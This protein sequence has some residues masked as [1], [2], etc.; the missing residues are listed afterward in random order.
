MY[1]APSAD[2]YDPASGFPTLIKPTK[3]EDRKLQ[4]IVQAIRRGKPANIEEF[5]QEGCYQRMQD[6][7]TA[8][9]GLMY[10]LSLFD[11]LLCLRKKLYTQ[12]YIT[13]RCLE[14]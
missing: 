1:R 13:S 3:L 11:F 9:I 2:E 6:V 14:R 8:Y 10:G 7:C 12:V 5:F 4:A